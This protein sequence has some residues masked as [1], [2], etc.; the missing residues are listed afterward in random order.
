[1]LTMNKV[2]RYDV[3]LAAIDGAKATNQ[4]VACAAEELVKDLENRI[5]DHASYIQE[6]GMGEDF[7][8]SLS[9]SSSPLR[10]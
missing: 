6:H 7:S 2:S 10:G 5:S 8:L 3:M 9:V 4:E 1:M